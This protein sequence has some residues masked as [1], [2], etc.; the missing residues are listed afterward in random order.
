ML[1]S[2]PITS[3]PLL[4]I[5]SRIGALIYRQGTEEESS[6]ASDSN[7]NASSWWKRPILKQQ[8]SLTHS[9]LQEMD[10][11]DENHEQFNELMDEIDAFVLLDFKKNLKVSDVK[12]KHEMYRIYTFIVDSKERI[13][14]STPQQV[15]DFISTCVKLL[16]EI[17]HLPPSVTPEETN[18]YCRSIFSHFSSKKRSLEDAT[19]LRR[20]MERKQGTVVMRE[21][22][23]M[24]PRRR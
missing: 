13:S 21:I 17:L 7:Q 16:I 3:T 20:Q 15:I 18:S 1:D 24:V 8:Q 10:T 4:P 12:T 9:L 23:G 14:K 11:G 22:R 2:I 6:D 19:Q 5:E